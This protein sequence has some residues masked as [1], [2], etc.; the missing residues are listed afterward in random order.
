MNGVIVE[1]RIE[2]SNDN[3]QSYHEVATGTWTNDSGW[4]WAQFDQTE[5]TNV[6]LYAVRTLSDQAGKNFASAAEIRIMAPKKEEPQPEQV[7]KQFL[8][9]LIGYAQSAKEKPEYEHVVPEVKKALDAALAKAVQ[10]KDNEKAS[11]EQVDEAYT[12]LLEIVHMLDFIGDTTSLK[13]LVDAVSDKTE[14][15]YTPST[16]QP[17]KSAL[18]AAN[19]V[20]KNENAL[21]ADIEAARTALETAVNGLVKRADFTK[22]QASV[23]E[24]K[25]RTGILSD[26][27][28]NPQRSI[29][30]R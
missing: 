28:K 25:K 22:L 13:V 1:Y 20:L 23:D 11:Q 30:K 29:R 27:R 4:K 18:D 7:N 9:F 6:R 21:D 15:D 24:A 12:E 19:E 5:A 14:K 26:I 17:F 8:E 2:V 16:W 3:G 10:V